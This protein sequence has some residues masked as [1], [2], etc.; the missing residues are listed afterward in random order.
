MVLDGKS[1]QEYPVN[2]N[3]LRFLF[4]G[5]TLI[6]RYIN[7]LMILFLILLSM[8]MIPLFTLSLIRHFICSNNWNW[9]LNLNKTYDTLRTSK[10]FY[11]N[12][13][14]SHLASFDWSYNAVAIDV[15]M[16]GSTLEEESFNMLVISLISELDWGPYFVSIAKTSSKK[17]GPIFRFVKFL[18]LRLLFIFS[19][20]PYVLSS[21]YL[22]ILGK[23]QKQQY[24]GL[25]VPHLLPLLNSWLIVEIYPA[26][27][28]FCSYYFGS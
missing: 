17:I 19:K 14:K 7:D 11:F 6:L 15:K 21:C 1:L 5:P 23:L 4:F 3:F 24:V 28:V 18:L 25:L 2:V 22:D 8:L 9:L 10:L 13:G 12:A 20:L 16:D 27:R 26:L